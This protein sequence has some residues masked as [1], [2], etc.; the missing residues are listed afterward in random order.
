MY[1]LLSFYT[2]LLVSIAFLG[3]NSKREKMI[4]DLTGNDHK[5]WYRYNKDTLRPYPI[6]YCFFKNGTFIGYF[7][8]DWNQNIRI[9]DKSP[10]LSEPIWKIINDSTVMF[11]KGDTFRILNLNKDSIILRS[12]Y[13]DSTFLKLKR[14]R[15][16]AT[17][18]L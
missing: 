16:Q 12:N 6:G 18:P 13:S 8:N 9:V 3:C 1:R 15:D 10:E 7:N 5:Y 4:K 2:I 14:D 11:G 17:K